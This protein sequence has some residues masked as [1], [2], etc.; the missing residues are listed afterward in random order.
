MYPDKNTVP[1]VKE[2]FDAYLKRLS[3]SGISKLLLE[4]RVYIATDYRKFRKA[5]YGG[6]N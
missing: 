6:M 5:V 4:K 2:I 3:T 1:T